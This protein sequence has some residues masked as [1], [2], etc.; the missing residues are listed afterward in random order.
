MNGSTV[1]SP[2]RKTDRPVLPLGTII[3]FQSEQE[4]NGQQVHH[5]RCGRTK[6]LSLR[7]VSQS[8]PAALEVTIA[9]I[10]HDD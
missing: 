3:P 9:T 7:I 10:G 2:A 1:I 8:K 5:D 4:E 6:A